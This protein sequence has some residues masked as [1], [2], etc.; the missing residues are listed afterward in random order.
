MFNKQNSNAHHEYGAFFGSHSGVWRNRFFC[1]IT[2]IARARCIALT[3]N[4]SYANQAKRFPTCCLTVLMA[5]LRTCSTQWR[6]QLLHLQQIRE[7]VETWNEKCFQL[8]LIQVLFIHHL[9]QEKVMSFWIYFETYSNT[10][11]LLR[12]KSVAAISHAEVGPKKKL[13]SPDWIGLAFK[14]SL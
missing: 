12:R 5:T 4:Q 14:W 13:S 2:E 11:R 7:E 1:T 8:E 3:E 6:A 9:T 10:P